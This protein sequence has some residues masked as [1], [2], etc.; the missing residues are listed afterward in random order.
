MSQII[1]GIAASDG[2]GIAKAYTLT[3]PDL[4]FE[5]KQIDDPVAEYQRI[6]DAFNQSISELAAIKQN[7]KSRLS[8]E[9]LEVFDAHIA[10]LSDPEMKNQIKD[11]IES[12]HVSA[13]EAM[14][15]VTT[16]FANVLAAMTDNKYMQERAA[17][18]KDVA[19]RALSHLL[20]K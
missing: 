7:A 18:V 16:N 11:E 9:E 8:D 14:T 5:K 19:K 20:G 6:E 13:E 4:S 12:Q 10:I 2:I 17:D 1:K 15:D 3:E